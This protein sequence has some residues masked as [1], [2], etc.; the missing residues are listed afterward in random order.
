MPATRMPKSMPST[1]TSSFSPW[2]ASLP[3]A[4]ETGQ[5]W[6]TQKMIPTSCWRPTG[7]NCSPQKSLFRSCALPFLSMKGPFPTLTRTMQTLCVKHWSNFWKASRLPLTSFLTFRLLLCTPTF[8]LCNLKLSQLLRTRSR[9]SSMC[10]HRLLLEILR[11]VM[12]SRRRSG[13]KTNLPSRWTAQSQRHDDED[14]GLDPQAE[15]P[16][17]AAMALEWKSARGS[18]NNRKILCAGCQSHKAFDFSYASCADAKQNQQLWPCEG[19]TVIHLEKVGI[20]KPG[21]KQKIT[22]QLG[23]RDTA[24]VFDM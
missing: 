17:Y 7:C 13:W 24:A 9:K 14:A 6:S 22:E 2:L 16:F 15:E 5:R 21:D 8:R 11:P 23:K 3:S 18:S 19:S 1:A 20:L 10:W 4:M 12:M